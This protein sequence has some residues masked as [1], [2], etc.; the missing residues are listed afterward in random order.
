MSSVMGWSR[1][2]DIGKYLVEVLETGEM[3]VYFYIHII[4]III[5]SNQI[6]LHCLTNQLGY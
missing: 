6:L 3:R 2:T 5:I 1:Q 4:I